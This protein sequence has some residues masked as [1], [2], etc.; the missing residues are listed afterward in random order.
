V[1]Q[2]LAAPSRARRGG[3]AGP[4]RFRFAAE[5]SI[6]ASRRAGSGFGVIKI[7]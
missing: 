7:P 5:A 6:F 3:R 1:A 4:A 2:P